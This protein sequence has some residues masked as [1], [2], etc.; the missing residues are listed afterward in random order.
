M[1]QFLFLIFIYFFISY[2]GYSQIRQHFPS[3]STAA[4]VLN[5]EVT[6]LFASVDDAGLLIIKTSNSEEIIFEKDSTQVAF[7]KIRISNDGKAVGWLELY[8]NNSTSY[9]IPLKLKIY[10][11]GQIHLFTGN[12]L[13]IWLWNF[14]EDS[15]QIAYEQETVHGGLGIHYELREIATGRLIAEYNPE[16]GQDNQPLEIQQNV[17]KWV[18]ELNNIY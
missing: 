17:P 2:T 7:D 15:R 3:D 1:N 9:P 12:G 8:D 18:E 14:T 5:D 16:Y 10:S 6:Y 11:G 13:P 4:K